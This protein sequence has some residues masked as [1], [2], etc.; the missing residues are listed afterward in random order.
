MK[1]LVFL[2]SLGLIFAV[3]ATEPEFEQ[4][5]EAKC[6]CP[7]PHQRFTRRHSLEDISC[8]R[9]STGLVRRADGDDEDDGGIGVGV[10]L[11][12]V[13]LSLGN[14]TTKLGNINLTVT[15]VT[16][17]LGNVEVEDVSIGNISIIVSVPLP[18]ASPIQAFSAFS[19]STSISSSTATPTSTVSST[20]VTQAAASTSGFFQRIV[21]QEN[22]DTTTSAATGSGL[23]TISLPDPTATATVSGGPINLGTGSVNTEIGN[24]TIFVGNVNVS[25]GDIKIKNITVGNIFVLVQI[26]QPDI[27]GALGNLT[28][29][30]NGITDS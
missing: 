29:T 10:N 28:N 1:L 13:G 14:I 11:P 12:S 24:I 23:S 4:S 15:N 30:L 25:V 2:L 8:R 6:Q 18:G 16:I 20:S 3:F 5:V 9:R 21:R 7:T 17:S 22:D 19:S 27:T 26:G